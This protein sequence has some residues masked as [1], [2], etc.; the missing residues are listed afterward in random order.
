MIHENSRYI[1]NRT[2]IDRNGAVVF[3]TRPR[4][5]FNTEN[6]TQY[7]VNG[8]DTIESIAVKKLGSAHYKWAIMDCNPHYLTELDVK[9]GDNILIPSIK[10][11]RYFYAKRS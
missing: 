10:D 5:I 8:N 3:Y 4:Q 6:C 7:S 11:V 2:F 9:T 1:N